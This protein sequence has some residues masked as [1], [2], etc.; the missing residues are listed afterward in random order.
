MF[1]NFRS[2]FHPVFFCLTLVCWGG[3]LVLSKPAQSQ[4]T[5]V[6]QGK[7]WTARDRSAFYMLDQGSRIIPL[8]WIE[9]LRL[10]NGKPFMYDGLKRYGFLPVEGGLGVGL[11]RAGKPGREFFGMTCAACHTRQIEVDGKAYQIDGGPALIDFQ[12]FL[13]DLDRAVM[14]VRNV[15][16]V[17]HAFVRTVLGEAHPAGEQQLRVA[18]NSWHH[19]FRMIMSRSFLRGKH[20]GVGRMDA[21]GMIFNRLT[22][23]DLGAGPQFTIAENIQPADAPVRYPYLWNAAKHSRV[24]WTGF[25]DNTVKI[26]RLTRNVGQ[27]LGVF[28]E[29][30]PHKTTVKEQNGVFRIFDLFAVNS[31]NFENLV[32]LEHLMT[33]IGAPKWPWPIDKQLAQRGGKLY[34]E[35]C[36]VCHRATP[37]GEFWDTPVL[38]GR[39]DTRAS[40]VLARRVKTGVFADA[41]FGPQEDARLVLQLTSLAMAAQW[42]KR[43][44]G[45]PADP[46]YAGPPVFVARQRNAAKLQDVIEQT[47]PTPPGYVARVL[48]GIWA[49]APYLH[50]GSVPTLADLLR[51]AQQRP[52][53]FDV[54]PTYDIERVGLARVQGARKSPMFTTGCDDRH[55]GNSRCGH[56]YG[57][58][59][60]ESDK[61]ALLEYLKQL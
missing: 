58:D 51:P 11:T 6:D 8:R 61:R 25:A 55:S 16:R 14:L 9:A 43:A 18:L 17:Y 4:Q 34:A 54:G 60:P 23:L 48:H 20:W 56:A 39:T 33:K 12:R 57:T 37:K 22:G 47:V 29:F 15:P 50:N 41:G 10:P 3:A 5:F 36:E 26:K 32:K 21:V 13:Q 35:Y 40:R 1:L 42:A 7:N 52:E 30:I 59:L 28:G 44:L 2:S 45:I 27:V 31:V 19:R 49:S 46:V 24:Q 53:S 38:R